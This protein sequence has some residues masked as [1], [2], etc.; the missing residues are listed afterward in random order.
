MILKAFAYLDLKSLREE[1]EESEQRTYGF[2][3]ELYYSGT[4][5]L[6]ITTESNKLWFPWIREK[7][8]VMRTL[9]QEDCFGWLDRLKRRVPSEGEWKLSMVKTL[10][11]CIDI[12]KARGT[13]DIAIVFFFDHNEAIRDQVAALGDQRVKIYSTLQKVARP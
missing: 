5:Y 6:I 10:L 7:E 3:Q 12:D 11:E 2:L 9:Y 4:E 8:L 13:S 1:Y